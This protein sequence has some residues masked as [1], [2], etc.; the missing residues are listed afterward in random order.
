LGEFGWVAMALW[1]SPAALASFTLNIVETG[2]NVVAT[3]SG[4]INT[5]A[6]TNTGTMTASAYVWPSANLG[7]TN[8]AV[9]VG[10]TAGELVVYFTGITGP[11][12]LGSG[13]QVFANSGSGNKVVILTNTG[14]YV[15]SGYVSGSALSSTSTWNGQT[16]AGLGLTPGTYT[17]TWGSGATADS[18][19]IN[20]GGSV[21]PTPV[22]S[23]L[24]LLIAGLIGLALIQWYRT[25]TA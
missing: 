16:L 20:I 15:P 6:L 22:P 18:F 8:S 17:Y 7:G 25:R 9:G 4:S 2:G 21:N 12:S 14:V 11:G 1:A 23:T 19:V 13:P 10:S 3:G 5:T 24:Y